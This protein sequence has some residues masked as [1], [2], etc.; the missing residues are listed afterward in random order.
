MAEE[1]GNLE[2]CKGDKNFLLTKTEN[3]AGVNKSDPYNNIGEW[4]KLN[5]GGD[6]FERE[7]TINKA[8]ESISNAKKGE[9]RASDLCN[10]YNTLV[11]TITKRTWFDTDISSYVK[12]LKTACKNN[13]V[14]PKTCKEKLGSE[15]DDKVEECSE[16]KNNGELVRWSNSN[17]GCVDVEAGVVAPTEE[18][19]GC[20]VNNEGLPDDVTVNYDPEATLN[21]GCTFKKSVELENK[22][23][24]CITDTC[25]EIG[26][27]ISGT[28][29]ITNKSS[30]YESFEKKYNNVFGSALEAVAGVVNPFN[31]RLSTEI[32]FYGEQVDNSYVLDLAKALTILVFREYSLSSRAKGNIKNSDLVMQTEGGEYLG[33]FSGAANSNGFEKF[34]LQL[35][36][37]IVR[38]RV[39]NNIGGTIV[40]KS[41]VPSIQRIIKKLG[42]ESDKVKNVSIDSEGLISLQENI[43]KI[44]LG[45]LLE[46]KVVGLAKLLK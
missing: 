14:K 15:Y 4:L 10:I 40:D 8:I 17:C 37:P 13:V 31:F 3:F 19:R 24:F 9:K 5:E 28:Q 29:V 20:M 23:C 12:K 27:C 41:V 7:D 26:N 11:D 38:V 21:F 6:Y 22:F 45:T 35:T 32:G 25:E 46:T 2:C 43:T 16:R 44:G 42:G 36:S 39:A 30:S 33:F 18:I 1:L 34:N